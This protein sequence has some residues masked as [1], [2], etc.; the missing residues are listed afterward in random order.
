MFQSIP[1]VKGVCIDTSANS[2]FVI[3]FVVY[4]GI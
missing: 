2:T 3:I 4:V 1:L